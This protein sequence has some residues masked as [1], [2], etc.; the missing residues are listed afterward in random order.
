MYAGFVENRPPVLWLTRGPE[1]DFSQALAAF[2]RH[3]EAKALSAQTLEWYEG[4]L[5]PFLEFARQASLSPSETENHHLRAF[6][7]SL[8]CGPA[9]HNGYLRA[10]RAFFGWL[11]REGYLPSNPAAGLEKQKEFQRLPSAL[12]SQQVASL[13][14][15][16]NTSTWT[17]RRDYALY[18][19]L[20][21]TGLR[22][23]EA[24]GLDLEDVNWA[25]STLVVMGKGR[26]QRQVPFGRAAKR[27]LLKWLEARGE[28]PGQSAV[29]VTRQGE[30]MLRRHARLQLYR[31]MEKARVQGVKKGPHSLRHTFATE[32]LRGGGDVFALQ[33]ILGHSTLE[34][35]RRYVSLLTDDLRQK[36]R[37]YSPMD[38]MLRR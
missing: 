36:H 3:G 10:L 27:A 4:K 17:G 19:L 9:T 31:H 14:R 2:L 13:L 29:F 37:L 23:S 12:S 5:R 15:V 24:L 38:R 18:V 16:V 8:S 11:H 1:A 28:I 34:M 33:K 35:T 26:K 20:L 30:R 7:A 32:W 6:L 22:I 25:E 21:D